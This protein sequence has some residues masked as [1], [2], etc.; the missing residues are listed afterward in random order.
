MPLPAGSSD[1]D[2]QVL[3]AVHMG[4]TLDPPVR[5]NTDNL[6]LLSNAAIEHLNHQS[7]RF[8]GEIPNWGNGEELFSDVDGGMGGIPVDNFE[9]DLSEFLQGSVHFGLMEGW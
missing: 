1:R 4:P 3:D 9:D 7:E 8:A 2:S 5:L 6:D